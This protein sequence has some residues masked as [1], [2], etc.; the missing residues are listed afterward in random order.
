MNYSVVH[1]LHFQNL[2]DFDDF[3]DDDMEDLMEEMDAQ[4]FQS[5]PVHNQNSNRAV[6]NIKTESW[7]ENNSLNQNGQIK[8]CDMKPSS[9]QMI[10]G[11]VRRNSSDPSSHV[12]AKLSSTNVLTDD[13]DAMDFED[14]MDFPPMDD[15][16]MT[17]ANT[18][19][20]AGIA[21]K[22][23]DTIDDESISNKIADNK[24]TTYISSGNSEGG[25]TKCFKDQNSNR[26]CGPTV[27]EIYNPGIHSSATVNHSS[28]NGDCS[29]AGEGMNVTVSSSKPDTSK[30]S[31]TMSVN[32][33]KGKT[34]LS[35]T[36][37]KTEALDK[38]IAANSGAPSVQVH[39]VQ[40]K[41]LENFLTPNKPLKQKQADV[42]E[43]KKGI[44][45]QSLLKVYCSQF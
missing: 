42:P 30:T 16:F 24:T 25:F 44:I 1:L 7:N 20:N 8:Q 5:P 29:R 40:Q 39:K 15:D 11:M 19:T 12:A 14:D 3:P 26:D 31:V 38:S 17:S 45:V 10:C 37:V 36:K 34:K 41:T 9:S 18:Q 21:M 13:L 2:A 33:N 27:S 35:L 4:D 32:K 22:P 6:N 28:N 23:K 43:N